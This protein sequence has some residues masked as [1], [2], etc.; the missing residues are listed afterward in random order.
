MTD[1]SL[2]FRVSLFG[3]RL[4]VVGDSAAM[5]EAL[6]RC[7]L[8]WL[9][10][11]AMDG[12][13]ADRLVEVRRAGD[14]S[15]LEVLIDGA[16]AD[17]A[18]SPLAAISSVQRALDEAVLRHQADVVVVH[19][20]VIGHR[21]HAVLLPAPSGA[22]KSTLVAELVRG[23]ALYLSDEYALIDSAGRV[24]P[25]PRALVLRDGSAE[26]RPVLAADLGG[27]VARE[28]L[29]VGLIVGLRYAGEAPLDAGEAP[30]D[31]QAVSQ[32]EGVL[33]LLRNTPQ[34]LAD[35]PWI[36]KPV[37][38]AVGTAACY[39]GRRGEAREAAR[40]LLRLRAAGA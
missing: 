11:A 31:V 25:Y 17:A 8:P 9:P 27:T 29:P 23:G 15:G 33:L 7:V 34:V 36:L 1:R 22:G 18:S 16:V 32:G 20:G 26:G 28:P 4:A 24:H 40:E 5:V 12:E 35:Q 21:G 14:G 3:V 30:L 39:T 19:G 38:R 2:G 37:E 10:R 6:D 13:T